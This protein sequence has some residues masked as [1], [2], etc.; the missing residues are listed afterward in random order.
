VDKDGYLSTFHTNT[1][2][3]VAAARLGLAPPV[4]SCPGWTVAD[5]VAHIGGVD[6]YWWNHVSS[7]AQEQSG[8]PPKETFDPYPGIPDFLNASW[9]GTAN[10]ADAPPTLIDWYAEGARRLEEAFRA[11]DPQEPIWHWSG[12]NR[13]IAHIRMQAIETATHRWDAENAHGVAQRI[14]SDL[15]RDGIDHHFEVMVPS[16]RS[17]GEHRA[18]A[19]ET[20]H[21]HCTDG[22]GEWFIRFDGEDVT[23]THEHAKADV[24]VRGPV[25]DLFLFLWGRVPASA[26]D[27]VG[28]ASLLDR[29]RELVPNP[30]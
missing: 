22:E 29:Y 1:D 4:P 10:P 21:F 18:G 11:L 26:L 8:F 12:D 27:V 20:F 19:G 2:G 14:D 25:S 9:D 7:R 6:W 23:V 24:A 28:D 15:A 5:L 30:T 17:T 3:L 13:A 16:G